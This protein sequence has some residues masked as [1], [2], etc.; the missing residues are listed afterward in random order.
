MTQKEKLIQI[1]ND[2]EYTV[3]YGNSEKT[4]VS[5]AMP[6]VERELV[7]LLADYLIE[8]GVIVNMEEGA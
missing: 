2:A 7:P 3:R 8:N 6:V 5:Y 4:I 1:L